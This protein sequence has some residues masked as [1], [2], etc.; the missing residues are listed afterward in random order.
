[1]RSGFMTS[2]VRWLAAAQPQESVAGLLFP[3]L[4]S[5]CCQTGGGVAQA[6]PPARLPVPARPRETLAEVL[7]WEKPGDGGRR[8]HAEDFALGVRGFGSTRKRGVSLLPCRL[9]VKIPRNCHAG[10][11]ERRR[12]ALTGASARSVHARCSL[13]R[14]SNGSRLALSMDTFGYL[15]LNV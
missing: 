7:L 1:M 15:F 6:S 14:P 11:A 13:L 12:C 9:N 2:P 8:R 4:R 5:S 3:W 10:S